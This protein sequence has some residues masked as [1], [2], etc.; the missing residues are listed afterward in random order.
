MRTWTAKVGLVVALCACI[1]LASG[2]ARTKKTASQPGA[3]PAAPKEEI[4]Y[5]LFSLPE[6]VQWVR[7]PD[8]A[9]LNAGVA[10]WTLAGYEPADSPA[11]VMYQKLVPAQA[12]ATLRRQVL[13]PLKDCPD[14]QVSDL[15]GMS[16]Y[17]DQIN[18]EAICSQL[19]KDNFGLISYIGIFS[20]QT[21]N[22][23]VITEVRTPASKK[24]GLL[25]FQNSEAQKQA[26]ASKILSELLY[27]LMETIRV[28][29]EK[30]LCI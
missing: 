18:I 30:N 19:G 24:A 1:V 25:T 15:R 28:C 22:H 7:N 13:E 4:A 16:K 17:S 10:E 9:L 8:E 27:R 29:N 26:E 3:E 2:C 23:M 20:D 5:L 21:A 14:T 6:Q 12:P 11:R